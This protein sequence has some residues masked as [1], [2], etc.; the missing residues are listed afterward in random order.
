MG[1]GPETKLKNRLMKKLETIPHSWWMK[2]HGSP[3]QTRGVPDIIGCAGGLFVG[4]E[5]KAGDN[6]PTTMQRFQLDKIKRAR[7]WTFVV[8]C[9]PKGERRASEEDVIE[10]VSSLSRLKEEK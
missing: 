5:L 6:D 7:G 2:V 8:R 1:Q 9:G 10:V 3:M 4:I